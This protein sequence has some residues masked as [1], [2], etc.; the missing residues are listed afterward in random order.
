MFADLLSLGC[1]LDFQP[2]QVVNCRKMLALNIFNN[3]VTEN[4]NP[5]RRSMRGKHGSLASVDCS[6]FE[7]VCRFTNGCLLVKDSLTEICSPDVTR[8]VVSP[9]TAT[10][11]NKNATGNSSSKLSGG[12]NDIVE[13]E[14]VFTVT[15]VFGDDVIMGGCTVEDNVETDGS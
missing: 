8:W 12:G 14:V 2:D 3:T 11:D 9:K 7:V 6:W 15:H 10:T 1:V 5:P 4:Y 13:S